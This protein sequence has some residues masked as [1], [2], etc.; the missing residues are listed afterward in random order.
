MKRLLNTFG[1]FFKASN[2]G[3]II[4]LEIMK[5]GIKKYKNCILV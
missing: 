5:T 4:I 2:L 3:F 1:K